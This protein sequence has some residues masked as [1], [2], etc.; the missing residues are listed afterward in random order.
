MKKAKSG[1]FKYNTRNRPT[2]YLS[3]VETVVAVEGQGKQRWEWVKRWVAVHKDEPL[4]SPQSRE[5][6]ER[7]LRLYRLKPQAIWDGHAFGPVVP[8]VTS[9]GQRKRNT[10]PKLRA[11]APRLTR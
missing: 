10:L 4:C 1:E 5:V 9:S 2:T 7:T 11:A 3:L 8:S 6:A